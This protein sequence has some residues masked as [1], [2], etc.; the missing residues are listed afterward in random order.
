MSSDLARLDPVDD[1][2]HV[3]ER[4]VDGAALVELVHDAARGG[5]A[6]HPWPTAGR[7]EA[8]GDAPTGAPTKRRSVELT[9]PNATLM[10][11]KKA[12]DRVCHPGA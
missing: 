5:G 11:N 10:C 8:R 12:E 9:R 2:V 1:T 3:L 6:H 4:V 7:V